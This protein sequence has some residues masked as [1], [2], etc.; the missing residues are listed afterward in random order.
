MAGLADVNGILYGTTQAGGDAKKC[1]GFGR[2]PDYGCG[3]VFEVTT[4]GREKVLHRFAGGTDGVA[5]VAGLAYLN[6]TFY[7]TT[8]YGGAP[9]CL[10]HGCGTIFKVEP[11]GKE[12]VLYRFVMRTAQGSLGGLFP[13]GGLTEAAG[14]LYGTTA[15]GGDGTCGSSSLR[16]SCG[17]VYQIKP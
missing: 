4:S 10:Y 17:T 9:R 12:T 13:E 3:I 1:V 6:G 7:G 5:P 8:S 2:Y 14:I 16:A 11:S 15:Y